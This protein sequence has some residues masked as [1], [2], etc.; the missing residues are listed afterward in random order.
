MDWYAIFTEPSKERYANEQLKARKF[1]TLFPHVLEWVGLKTPMARLVHKAYYPRYLFVQ[2]EM[3]CLAQVKDCPGVTSIVRST[4][5]MPFKVP[6]EAIQAVQD[7]TDVLGTVHEIP[8]S[9]VKGGLYRGH[10]G[11]KVRFAENNPLWNLV[12]TIADVDG[13]T[14]TATLGMLKVKCRTDKIAEM[15]SR[16]DGPSAMPRI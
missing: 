7:K 11:D 16:A 12:A 10:R 8:A 9:R 14:L 13:Y 2:T 4:D 1:T 5:R 3:I 6:L 15:E